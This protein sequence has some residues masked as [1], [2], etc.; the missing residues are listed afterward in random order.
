M[1]YHSNTKVSVIFPNG[2]DY[3]SRLGR[4]KKR[5]PLEVIERLVKRDTVI[6]HG[7]TYEILE[8]KQEWDTT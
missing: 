8:E 4:V 5:L 7:T 2:G 1:T 3:I 6:Y